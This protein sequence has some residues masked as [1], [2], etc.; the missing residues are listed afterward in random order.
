MSDF[1]GLDIGTSSIRVVRVKKEGKGN[2]SLLN[3]GETV[4]PQPGI[5]SDNKESWIEVAKAIKGLITDLKMR[6]KNVV[7]GLAEEDTISRLKWFPPMK[8]NE[9][10][11][12]L[13]FEAET[14]IPHPLEKVQIDYQVV[15][16]DDEGRVLVFVIAA[17]KTVIKK[18]LNIAKLAGLNVVALETP[19]ASLARVFSVK[20]VPTLIIDIGARYTG[21]IMSRDGNVFLT[22]SVPIGMEAFSRGVSVSLGIDKNS[23]ESYCQ[24]YGLSEEDLQGKVRKAL[25]P[26]LKKFFDEI[27][28]AIY[29]FKEEWGENVGVLVLAGKGAVIPG[30]S[31]E[32]IRTLGLEVQVAQPFSRVNVPEK[33]NIDLKKEGPRFSVAFGLA[34]RGLI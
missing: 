11:A 1:F 33:L 9:V 25:I 21:L 31:E 18:Y 3:L 7:L 10:R 8:E 23:A 19:S 20:K 6:T 22:R 27:K 28:K 30:L 13:E 24:A 32:L 2:L 29:S 14:F 5:H 15:D 17:L 34:V 4:S 26:L 12:A 16:K